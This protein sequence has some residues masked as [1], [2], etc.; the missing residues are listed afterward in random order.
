MFSQD[1][2]QAIDDILS[3]KYSFLTGVAGT[4]KSYLLNHLKS[5]KELGY[6][7]VTASTGIAALAISGSTIHRWAGI[8]I[9][10]TWA[11]VNRRRMQYVYDRIM[12]FDTIIIDEI[13]MIDSITLGLVNKVCQSLGDGRPFGHFKVIFVGD[14]AQ[15]PPVNEDNGFA[16]ESAA[17][18]E[19]DPKLCRLVTAHRQSSQ[20]FVDL[21][22]RARLGDL[23]EQDDAILRS[24]VRAFNDEEVDL[25]TR[26]MSTNAE[27]EHINMTRLDKLPGGIYYADAIEFGQDNHLVNIDKNCLS[28]RRLI[29]KIGARVMFTKNTDYCTNGEVGTI[30]DLA[31]NTIVVKKDDGLEVGVTRAKWEV[32]EESKPGYTPAV[33]AARS[34][35][36][37]RLAYAI[38]IHKSQGMTLPRV[39]IN[40]AK[41]FAYGQAYVALSR[42]KSLDGLNLERWPGRECVRMHPTVREWEMGVRV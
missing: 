22:G 11:E 16:F 5:M 35:F 34:Q 8:G 27:V 28:P 36:P 37:L 23:T 12:P 30:V 39:S 14:M 24:R 3:S 42:A 1:Q 32:E 7:A 19:A 26:L 2:Q 25:A 6:A 10:K 17:W 21:L 9:A 40:L 18:K 38:T 4:G 31:D 20:D 41:C 13:S 15:L 29:F 33:I